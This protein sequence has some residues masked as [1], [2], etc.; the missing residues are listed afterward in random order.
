MERVFK[1]SKW[2]DYNTFTMTANK[3]EYSAY[4]YT[5]KATAVQN[6]SSL[7]ASTLEAVHSKMDE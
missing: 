6:Y 5:R 2:Y 3:T 1:K 4:M 7:A